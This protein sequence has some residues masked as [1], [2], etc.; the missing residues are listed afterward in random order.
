VSG[1][2]ALLSRA[3]NT[4]RFGNASHIGGYAEA[5]LRN[6]AHYINEPG[7]RSSIPNNLDA[8]LDS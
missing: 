4:S 5:G 3:S 1:V 2:Q 7:P 6:R 8:D